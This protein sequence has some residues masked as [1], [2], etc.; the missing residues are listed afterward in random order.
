MVE[1]LR[2]AFAPP[3]PQS[4]AGTNNFKRR[5]ADLLL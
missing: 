4:Q 2:I 3:V 5:P 1:T